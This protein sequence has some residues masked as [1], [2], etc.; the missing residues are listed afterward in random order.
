[1]L[2]RAWVEDGRDMVELVRPVVGTE[3]TMLI[4]HGPLA[5]L[6]VLATGGQE[7]VCPGCGHRWSPRVPDPAKCPECSYRLRRPRPAA[8][9]AAQGR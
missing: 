7:K 8:A 4:Y 5:E 6:G 1:L 2:V 9:P 3:E